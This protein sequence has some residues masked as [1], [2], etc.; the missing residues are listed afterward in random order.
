[1]KI[2]K[3]IKKAKLKYLLYTQKYI[4]KFILQRNI[5]ISYR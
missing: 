5:F 1:M 2:N 3:Y 4:T